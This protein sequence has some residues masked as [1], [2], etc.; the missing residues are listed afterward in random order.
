MAGPSASPALAGGLAGAATG[1]LNPWIMGE[2]E[3]EYPSTR[4]RAVLLPIMV[5]VLFAVYGA[6]NWASTWLTPDYVWTLGMFPLLFAFLGG[7]VG[8]PVLGMLTALPLALVQLVPL[9][10]LLTVGWDGGWILGVAG[11]AA[12]AVAGAVNGFLY[13]R[14]IM[15]EYD[16]RRTGKSAIPPPGST[17]GP[18]SS[19]SLA[20]HP[21]G[22]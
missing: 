13:D 15:P 18:G 12:G 21:E 6:H 9:V 22:R 8:R 7:L 10:A 3:R 5:A 11:A 16:K 14:W 19:G 2:S 4:Q 1:R 17:E 20:E